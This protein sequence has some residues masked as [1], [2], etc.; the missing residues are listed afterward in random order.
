MPRKEKVPKVHKVKSKSL[1]KKINESVHDLSKFKALS[2]V[3]KNQVLAAV[4]GSPDYEKLY[5]TLNPSD[6]KYVDDNIGNPK[7]RS[8][9]LFRSEKPHLEKISN[10]TPEQS[11]AAYAF[12]QNTIPEAFLPENAT[13][14]QI[15]QAQSQGLPGLLK[16]LQKPYESPLNTQLNQMFG[17]MANPVLQNFLNPQQGNQPQVLFPSQLPQ[18][19]AQQNQQA[20]GGMQDL[21]GQLGG[22]LGQSA[23]QNLPGAFNYAQQNAPIAAEYLQGLGNSALQKGQNV[24]DFIRNPEHGRASSPE[25]ESIPAYF[26]RRALYGAAHPLESAQEY[27]NMVGSAGSAGLSG[28]QNL[29]SSLGSY[30][31]K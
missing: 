30:F 21:L 14:E 27:A 19:Y 22:Q 6:K 12:L 2:Q 5:K 26:G 13:Q 1:T 11:R 29:L 18:Y 8:A 28:L 31:Q 25:G 20:S 10:L 3:E 17:H 9:G 23:L 16:E 15:Q 4:Q 24:W 7:G